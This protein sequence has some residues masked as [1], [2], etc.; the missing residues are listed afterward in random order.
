M[1]PIS[2]RLAAERKRRKWGQRAAADFFGITQPAYGQWENGED[3][4]AARHYPAIRAFLG[5]DDDDEFNRL[6]VADRLAHADMTLEEAKELS[7]L[8][9]EAEEEDCG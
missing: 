4:P 1:T 9:R 5:I 2:S 7:L 6:I 3:Q 8:L